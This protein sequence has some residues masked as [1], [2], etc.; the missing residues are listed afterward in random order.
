[1][2]PTAFKYVNALVERIATGIEGFDALVDGGFPKNS[3]VLITGAPGTGKTLFCLETLVRAC[4]KGETCLFISFEQ[5]AEDVIS[6]AARF[7]WNLEK[8]VSEG[9]LL[10][11]SV[12][13][14]MEADALSSIEQLVKEKNVS[15]VAIDSLTALSN[16]P[17]VIK[18]INIIQQSKSFDSV[19]EVT[20]MLGFE[21]RLRL[22]VHYLVRKF[23]S[24]KGVTTLLISDMDEDS[25][26]LSK[27][28][29]SEFLCDGVVVLY[30]LGLGGDTSRTL[31]VRKMRWTAHKNGFFPLEFGDSGLVV[32]SEEGTS[33]MMK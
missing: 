16:Y 23:K 21:T 17:Y 33:V 32:K 13:L 18:I 10:V 5:S 14:L 6:Q 15:R 3:T 29:A 4:E 28:G 31:Q 8:H 1:M 11:K 24:M 25:K 9:R 26:L 20:S 2:I 22:L 7:N 19:Q 30:Y 12:D 27:D